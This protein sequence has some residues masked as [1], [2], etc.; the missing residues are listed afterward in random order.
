MSNTERLLL[1]RMTQLMHSVRLVDKHLALM[2][3]NSLLRL[4]LDH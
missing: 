4:F 3:S 2:F 1:T